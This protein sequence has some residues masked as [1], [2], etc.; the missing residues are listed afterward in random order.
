M[1]LLDSRTA[2]ALGGA[3]L[4]TLLLAACGQ[5][6]PLLPSSVVTAPAQ[7]ERIVSDAGSARPTPVPYTFHSVDDPAADY[8]EVTGINA[9]GKIVG[10]I[11][12][13]ISALEEGYTSAPPYLKFKP[14]SLSAA[15]VTTLR[16]LDDKRNAV[17]YV[18]VPPAFSGTWALVKSKTLFLYKCPKEGNG[19]DHVTKLLGVNDN[20]TAVGYYINSAGR[21]VPMISNF[22]KETCINL[23]VPSGASGAEATGI[24]NKGDIAGYYWRGRDSNT[25]GFL[26]KTDAEYAFA[27]PGATSTTVYGLDYDEQIVG[28]FTDRENHTHGFILTYPTRARS[29]QFWQ[30]VDEPKATGGMTVITG[31]NLHHAIC[32]YYTDSAGKYHGFVATVSK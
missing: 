10:N 13:A 14:V 2:A 24:N 7:K 31:I 32:G 22:T 1:P 17:G 18:V 23:S 15:H 28:S 21:D 11:E 12:I 27:Y 4:C 20:S 8:N 26:I 5:A 29:Q 6:R 19:R 25:T 9:R 16:A 3:G 30:R